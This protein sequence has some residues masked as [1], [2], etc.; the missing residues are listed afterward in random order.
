M[1]VP[2]E[3]VGVGVGLGDWAGCKAPGAELSP[4][5]GLAPGPVPSGL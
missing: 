4:G 3:D 5:A 2:D 1:E